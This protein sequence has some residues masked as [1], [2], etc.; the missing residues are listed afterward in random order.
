MHAFVRA[1][2]VRK[3]KVAVSRNR[4]YASKTAR[5]IVDALR[6]SAQRGTT[7]ASGSDRRHQGRHRYAVVGDN[8]IAVDVAGTP[9]GVTPG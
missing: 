9:H 5:L 4:A 1:S 7:A 3:T 6:S 2:T 8:T